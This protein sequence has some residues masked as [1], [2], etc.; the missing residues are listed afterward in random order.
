MPELHTIYDRARKISELSVD[1]IKGQISPQAVADEDD[2]LK[3]LAEFIFASAGCGHFFDILGHSN[4]SIRILTKPHISERDPHVREVHVADASADR[5][6]REKEKSQSIESVEYIFMD[7][8]KDL[9]E[10][11]LEAEGYD[12]IIASEAF[13]ED[14]HASSVFKN[15]NALLATGRRIFYQD[16]WKTIP[17]VKYLMGIFPSWWEQQMER[18]EKPSISPQKWLKIPQEPEFAKR[19]EVTSIPSY[20]PIRT[21][22]V[23]Q[24]RTTSLHRGEVTLLYL[25]KITGWARSVGNYLVDT[26]YNVTWTALGESLPRGADIISFIDLERPFFDNMSQDSFAQLQLLAT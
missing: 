6:S 26:G 24:P 8:Q 16:S 15:I 14:S 10:Q 12:L 18:P 20:C 19:F 22:T 5:I 3:M 7:I 21:T 1:L 11:G 23:S 25:S 17:L 13:D 4:P 9:V 2:T